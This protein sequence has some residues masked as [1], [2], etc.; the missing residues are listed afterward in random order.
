MMINKFIS[1]I[2]KTSKDLQNL[3]EDKDNLKK[4]EIDILA[5]NKNFSDSSFALLKNS[6]FNVN[7]TPDVWMNFYEK[8][9]EIKYINRKIQ[10]DF[11]DTISY[12]KMFNVTL[13][14]MNNKP[15]FSNEEN[16]GK[17]V[18]MHGIYMIY[19]NLKKVN[20]YIRF[21]LIYFIDKI[22]RFLLYR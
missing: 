4:E 16:K 10:N 19:Q 14:E 15:I 3:Y 8:V 1:E 17:C 6:N 9:K 21:I 12:E 22:W 18:D 11:N 13:D 7:R 20:L 2:K 5:G